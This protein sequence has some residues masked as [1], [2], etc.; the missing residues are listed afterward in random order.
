[1]VVLIC[2][3][4]DESMNR[5]ESS[6]PHSHCCHPHCTQSYV[7]FHP[8]LFHHGM[9]VIARWWVA[10]RK[11]NNERIES[12]CG[13]HQESDQAVMGND[14]CKFRDLG[15]W[16]WNCSGVRALCGMTHLDPPNVCRGCMQQ[17]I[18]GPSPNVPNWPGKLWTSMDIQ[19]C[20]ATEVLDQSWWW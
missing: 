4:H 7:V 19:I 1:M 18:H 5:D 2:I 20:W 6:I 11:R 12:S 14:G 3:N 15:H 17:L 10:P 9:G 13:G 8:P 16:F